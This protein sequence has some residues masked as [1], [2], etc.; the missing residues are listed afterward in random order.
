M[1][2]KK[3]VALVLSSGGARGLAGIGAIEELV[4]QGYTITSIA[5]TSMG[6]LIGGMY[7]A[8]K[9]EEAKEWLL[10]V[11]KKKMFSLSDF[12]LSLNHVVK[13][14]KIIQALKKVVPD[15]NIEDLRLP[16]CAVAT[17]IKS[18]KEVVFKEGSLYEAIRASISIPLFFRPEKHGK[19]FLVDGGLVNGLPLNRV[20]RK[21]GDVLVAVNVSAPNEEKPK[22]TKNLIAEYFGKDK[23]SELEY[24]YITLMSQ[25]TSV[26]IQQNI[27]LTMQ[28]TRPDVAV[29]IPSNRFDTFDFF[30]A[31]DIIEN[32]RIET[33]KALEAY[34]AERIVD[35]YI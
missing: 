29:S 30:R 35:T 3:N 7:A 19:N 11:D 12:S 1:K 25:L 18:G 8:G 17:D 22:K 4:A 27:Q 6:S 2:R 26:L 13:G 34:E 33:R 15:C 24:N 5:G 20:A 14:E 31:E 23:D 10:T 21:R 9:L 28:I 32:G 16:Y